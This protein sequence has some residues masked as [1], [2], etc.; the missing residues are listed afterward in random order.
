MSLLILDRLFSFHEPKNSAATWEPNA[1]IS[2]DEDESSDRMPLAKRQRKLDLKE[3]N[4]RLFNNRGI[5]H[6]KDNDGQEGHF[7]DMNQLSDDANEAIIESSILVEG[8][9]SNGLHIRHSFHSFVLSF[10]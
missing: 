9:E 4:D 10:I 1:S 2:N 7:F 8:L 5:N 6:G 3:S